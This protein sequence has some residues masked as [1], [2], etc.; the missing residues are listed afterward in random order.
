MTYNY[1]EGYS[2]LKT[3]LDSDL[4]ITRHPALPS[5]D[6]MSDKIAYQS[7]I[8]AV[9]VNIRNS[10]ILF[11]TADKT[12]GLRTLKAFIEETIEILE[13]DENL[14]QISII[15][16]SIYAI[17]TSPQKKDDYDIADKAF[18]INTYAKMLNKMLVKKGL[19]PIE[20]SIGMATDEELVIKGGTR[21]SDIKDIICIGKAM[22]TATN[23]SALEDI[24]DDALLFSEES[25]NSFIELLQKDHTNARSW[26]TKEEDK[27]LGTYYTA[28]ITKKGFSDFIENI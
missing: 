17:Y 21:D 7:Y 22:T 3:I 8:T 27:D 20:I 2:R 13:D 14:R 12:E 24:N 5:Y 1:K 26:F 16:K 10:T 19:S 11:S 6:N 28:N 9:C 18:F 15:D 23:L 4:I 25:F